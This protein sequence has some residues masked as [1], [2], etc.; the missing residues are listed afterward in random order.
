MM[1]LTYASSPSALI[2]LHG[3][4]VGRNLNA[5]TQTRSQTELGEQRKREG[6]D[7]PSSP[8][9]MDQSVASPISPVGTKVFRLCG[10]NT[11]AGGTMRGQHS[12]VGASSEKVPIAQRALTNFLELPTVPI[13]SYVSSP[14]SGLHVL[15][16]RVKQA[17][18]AALL[19]FPPTAR[20]KRRLPCHLHSRYHSRG[21][22]QQSIPSTAH[23]CC[24]FVCDSLRIYYLGCRQY[25]AGDSN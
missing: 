6:L 11:V 13:G 7:V 3:R 18:L 17:W 14:I 15:D 16:P 19:L 22:S 23:C 4:L 20:P 12:P 2:P 25:N 9:W 24:G 1:S 8:A 10:R 5:D 21:T